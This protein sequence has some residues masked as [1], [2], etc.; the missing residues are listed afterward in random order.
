M[1]FTILHLFFFISFSS[2]SLLL[3]FC[4]TKKFDIIITVFFFIIPQE[5][6]VTP[7]NL[8][9]EKKKKKSVSVSVSACHPFTISPF[10][11]LSYSLFASLVSNRV[12]SFY[13]S[14][15]YFQTSA[16]LSF[17][18]VFTKKHIC[19][20]SLLPCCFF[21]FFGHLFFHGSLQLLSSADEEKSKEIKREI[22]KKTH[23][24]AKT[25][26]L[27]DFL[28]FSAAFQLLDNLR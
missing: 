8:G 23:Q 25:C 15:L 13:F 27:F 4:R 22:E 7:I 19:Y 21:F 26:K 18:L 5:K 28:F 14:L 3:W 6:R 16:L 10:F 12:P 2:Y 20:L 11:F 1:S 17:T 9:K 24:K